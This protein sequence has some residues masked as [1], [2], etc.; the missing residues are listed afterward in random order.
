M[1]G[2]G[3]TLALLK[4]FGNEMHSVK[5]AANY[6]GISNQIFFDIVKEIWSSK[7]DFTVISMQPILHLIW[8][9]LLKMSCFKKRFRY[10]GVKTNKKLLDI[11]VIIAFCKHYPT[12]NWHN[13]L[14]WLIFFSI[15][16]LANCLFL[17]ESLLVTFALNSMLFQIVVLLMCFCDI[18]VLKIC[19]I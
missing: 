16:Y 17:D 18:K 19:Y 11:Q 10:Q 1:E 5:T 13:P 7:G 15:L 4:F 9:F 12:K 3:P 6:R 14:N 8:S 2:E